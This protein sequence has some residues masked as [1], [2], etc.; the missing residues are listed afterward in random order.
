MPQSLAT[1]LSSHLYRWAEPRTVLL[2]ED[3]EHLRER[4]ATELREAGF[5][6]V[7]V[8]DGLEL[9]DYLESS[10]DS[11]G[12]LRPPDVIVSEATMPGLDG[13]DVQQWLGRRRESIPFILLSTPGLARAPEQ[14]EP[15]GVTFVLEKPVDLEALKAAVS[16]A[17]LEW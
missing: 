15:L 8:E 16:L 4:M 17:A 14:V 1:Q 12:W 10:L 13:L 5:R 11:E 3:D 6:V 9:V 7:E 2:A